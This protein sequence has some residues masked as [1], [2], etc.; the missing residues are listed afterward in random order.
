MKNSVLLKRKPWANKSNLTI[1]SMMKQASLQNRMKCDWF[2]SKRSSKTNSHSAIGL[3]SITP[4]TT[5]SGLIAPSWS[6]RFS[7]LWSRPCRCSKKL[8]SSRRSN[9]CANISKRI[10]GIKVLVT[11]S[12]KSSPWMPQCKQLPSKYRPKNSSNNIIVSSEDSLYFQSIKLSK[13]F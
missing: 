12:R 13:Y 1:S 4:G 9:S 7:Y 8:F 11:T 2:S 10:L 6:R 5:I 3:T